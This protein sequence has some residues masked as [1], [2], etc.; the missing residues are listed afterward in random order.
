MFIMFVSQLKGHK[1][2]RYDI[3]SFRDLQYG[4][5]CKRTIRATCTALPISQLKWSLHGHHT[6]Y[7]TIKA[8]NLAGLSTTQTSVGYRHDIQL[9]AKG[10]IHDVNPTQTTGKQPKV[11]LTVY[12]KH[13]VFLL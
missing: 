13:A 10:I 5:T 4:G 3:Q 12:L 7:F 1:E 8:T 9:P 11:N 2:H 6:Y